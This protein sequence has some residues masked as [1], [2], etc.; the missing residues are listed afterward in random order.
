MQRKLLSSL[1]FLLVIL[2]ILVVSCA[3]TPKATII[4]KDG[5]EMILIPAGEFIMGSPEG[6]GNDDEH[7]QHTVFL[8]AFYIDKYEVTNAQ[9]KKFMDATGHKAPLSW[10][11]EGPFYQPSQPVV[12]VNWYDAAAYAKW[13]GKRLPTETEWEKAARGTDGRKYPWG[14]EWDSSKCNSNVNGDGYKYIAP[15]GSFPAGASPYG[16]MDMAG[17]VFE[18]CAD[19]YDGDYYSRTPQKNPKRSDSGD[20]R[21]MRGGAWYYDANVLRCALRGNREPTFAILHIGFR[22][23]QDVTP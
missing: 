4:G 22:C 1:Y 13:A 21:V 7:P 11:S 14:N 18:W 16:V 15:V 10:N 12:G 20:W 19:W 3:K 2:L 17:N 23:A 6:E 8:D 9:Y 5:A